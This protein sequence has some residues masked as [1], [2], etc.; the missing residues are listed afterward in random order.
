MAD[1]GDD[2]DGARRDR[3]DKALVGER[4]QVLEAAAAAREDDDVDAACAEVRD[5]SCDRRR[6]TRS[7]YVRLGDEHVRRWEARRDR[8]QDVALC[9]SVVAGDKPDQ[10]GYAR[11]RPLATR[12]EE[13][14]RRE[15]VLQSLQRREM[16]ADAEAF[17]RQRPEMEVAAL[18]VQLRPAVDVHT[19]AVDEIETQ[20]VELPARDLR[21]ETGVALRVLEREEDSRPPLLPPKLR[22]L[23]LDPQRRQLLQVRRDAL[24]ERAHR[25]DPAPLDLRRLDLHEALIVIPCQAF[26]LAW[27][28]PVR[29]QKDLCGRLV[30]AAR[31][32]ELDGAVQVG[33][34]MRD[35]LSERQRIAG[36]DEHV[37]PPGLDLFPF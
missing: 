1:G 10:R 33:L 21:V 19:L 11:Q 37:Q 20:G 34:G 15:L 26:S 27:A 16:R 2:R 9:G 28:Y 35:L 3:A 29:L 23:A 5:R 17:D 22:H 25:I 36:L 18:L 30:R 13:A 7:L 14:L 12:S 4:Q 8:R 32:H 31:Q 6:C 24:V